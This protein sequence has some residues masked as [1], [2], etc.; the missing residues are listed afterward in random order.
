MSEPPTYRRKQRP[1]CSKLVTNIS[2]GSEATLSRWGGQ[3]NNFCVAYY[4]NMLCAKYY[5]NTCRSTYVDTR[6]KW[7]GDCIFDSAC[8][9]SSA[10]DHHC[11]WLSTT[12][13][14]FLNPHR[15]QQSLSLDCNSIHVHI[16][17]TEDVFVLLSTV[18]VTCFY[19][20]LQPVI[21]TVLLT[22]NSVSAGL[23]LYYGL[24]FLICPKFSFGCIL[25]H[26]NCCLLQMM[27]LQR[28]KLSHS[29]LHMPSL[30][31][32]QIA[33]FIKRQQ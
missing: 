3:I 9:V 2:Q 15:F 5:T 19:Y 16:R 21:F 1:N 11:C 23:L 24:L 33:S 17:N 6:V 32:N 4:L 13:I 26:S 22:F 20:I 28:M 10:S 18:A 7:A 30:V 31:K 12:L 27:L 25:V 14:V 8:S 29:L